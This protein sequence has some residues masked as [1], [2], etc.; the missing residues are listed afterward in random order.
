MLRDI[1]H[2]IGGESFSSGDRSGDVFD[3]NKG[4]VQARKRNRSALVK[5]RGAGEIPR[6]AWRKRRSYFRPD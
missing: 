4:S 2:F 6:P 5:R 1:D 3:P